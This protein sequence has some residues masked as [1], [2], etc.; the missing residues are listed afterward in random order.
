MA[1]GGA[2]GVF[3]RQ[4]NQGRQTGPQ[5]QGYKAEVNEVTHMRNKLQVRSPHPN[6]DLKFCRIHLY[7]NHDME[8]CPN[9]RVKVD[10]MV[11][12]RY[13]PTGRN[14]M[15]QPSQP[16]PTSYTYSRGRGRGTKGERYSPAPCATQQ[17]N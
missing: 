17:A 7:D 9:V 5:N 13:R 15:G 1:Q 6:L 11:E 10:K 14:H 3:P 4:N 2:K 8:E 12:N 16:Q